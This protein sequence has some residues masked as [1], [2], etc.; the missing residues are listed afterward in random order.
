MLNCATYYLG[1]TLLSHRRSALYCAGGLNLPEG[2]AW[3]NGLRLS[4]S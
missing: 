4:L 3:G 1:G 2:L